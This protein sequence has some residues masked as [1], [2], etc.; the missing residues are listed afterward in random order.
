M[1]L[2]EQKKAETSRLM[3]A[4]AR[5]MFFEYGFAKVSTEDLCT[6]AGVTRGALY[7]NFGGKDELFEAVVRQINDDICDKLLSDGDGETTIE[8]FTEK[9]IAYLDCALDPEVQKILFVDGPSVL[10]QKLRDIDAQWSIAPLRR[11]IET[12]QD[13]GICEDADAEA[14]AVML[15]GA[16]IDSAQW[17]AEGT[18]PPA[19]LAQGAATLRRL[20][21]N[22]FRNNDQP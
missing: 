18:D 3:I 12:L 1:N 10:G 2:R 14:L 22:L 21:E 8:S 19:R 11:A 17:I 20:I 16:M 9:C 4:T 5:R 15:N 13:Q 7:H 6:A